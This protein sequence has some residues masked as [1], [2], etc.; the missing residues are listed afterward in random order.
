MTVL[1]C[2][3][4]F[5]GKG[6]L[7]RPDRRIFGERSRGTS[8]IGRGSARHCQRQDYARRSVVRR[9]SGEHVGRPRSPNWSQ[10]SCSSPIRSTLPASRR[11][12]APIIFLGYAP[13]RMFVQ[14]SN[15]PFGSI[16]ELQAALEV[17]PRHFICSPSS[18]ALGTTSGAGNWL[19]AISNG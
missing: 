18:T 15:D 13:E 12:C 10:G 17:D 3:L 5:V 6:R 11:S 9:P 7:D 8:G 16:E 2:D 14:G 19:V 1:R 4:P